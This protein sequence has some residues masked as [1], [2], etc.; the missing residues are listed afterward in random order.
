MEPTN[1]E[2]EM[3]IVLLEK[4]LDNLEKRWSMQMEMNR[5]TLEIL[6]TVQTIA[7]G[8]NKQTNR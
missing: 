5:Q 4:M 3:R 2:L 1:K 8:D 6:K 7:K